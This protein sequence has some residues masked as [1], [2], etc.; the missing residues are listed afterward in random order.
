MR[1]AAIGALGGRRTEDFLALVKGMAGDPSPEVRKTLLESLTG[2][3]DNP[4]AARLVADGVT[5]PDQGVRDQALTTFETSTALPP[6]QMLADLLPRV[7]GEAGLRVIA[8]LRQQEGNGLASLL[9]PGFADRTPAEQTAILT[10]VAGHVDDATLGLVRLGLR[11]PQAAVQRTA[12]LRL[13]QFPSDTAMPELDAVR[14]GLAPE[15]ATL[16]QEVGV[17]LTQRTLFPFLTQPDGQLAYAAETEFPAR[18]GTLPLVSPDGQWVAY[19]D[20][21]GSRPGGSGGFGRSNLVSLVHAVHPDGT[22]DRIL[23]DMFLRGWMAD[24]Q[25]VASARDGFAALTDVDG[26]VVAEFGDAYQDPNKVPAGAP[27]DWRQRDMRQ[28]EGT[29]RMPHKQ[30]LA[31]MG[32]SSGELGEDGRVRPR[33][34]AARPAAVSGR[35]ALP[36]PR[37]HSPRAD[38]RRRADQRPRGLVP[39]GSMMVFVNADGHLVLFNYDDLRALDLGPAEAPPMGRWAGDPVWRPWDR[40]GRR[41]T[42]VRDGQIWIHGSDGS[43]AHQLTFDTTPKRFPVFSP[44][45]TRIAYIACQPSRRQFVEPP[46]D[47]WVVDIRTTLAVRVTRP[48]G[49][50]TAGLDWLDRQRLIFDRLGGVAGSISSTSLRVAN[51][52]QTPGE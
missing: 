5:D 21:G 17:E 18:S 22:D 43:G 51:L 8:L 36:G 27:A 33:W 15:L 7:K 29:G 42:F 49:L 37:R 20:V 16:A 50:R 6:L 40:E 2:L 46:A 47:V 35:R 45:G 4:T 32:L 34:Q 39:G 23:S 44:D 13:L 24:S 25:R 38:V 19:Q 31:S 28:R 11:A 52:E 12:L 30:S 9:K 48:D 26:R 3:M 1:S 41:L 10:A 14:K